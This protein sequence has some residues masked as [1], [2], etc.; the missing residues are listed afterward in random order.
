MP[1]R[2]GL[3]Y[4]QSE[5]RIRPLGESP[6][7]TAHE[8]IAADPPKLTWRDSVLPV[9]VVV[10]VAAILHYIFSR[11]I[12]GL[13][14]AMLF[15]GSR[16]GAILP[17]SSGELAIVAVIAGLSLAVKGRNR[18]VDWT[19]CLP[20]VLVA[21]WSAG[22]FLSHTTRDFKRA[23]AFQQS[24]ADYEDIQAKM[25]DPN[26]LTTLKPPISSTCQSA[27]LAAL[28]TGQRTRG[29]PLTSAEAHAILTNLGSD[30]NIEE[31]VALSRV[32]SVDDLQWLALHGRKDTRADVGQNAHTPPA[33]RR[34]LMDD[35]EVVSY[36]IGS[37]AATQ[38]CDPEVNRAFWNR[39]NRK[40]LPKTD[41]A[42]QELADNACTPKDILLE[43]KT[44][45]DPAGP[46]ARATLLKL[47][48]KT[49]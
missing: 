33:T 40:N 34:R 36:R 18:G 16:P 9:G 24:I 19:Y 42:Y 44:F 30:P 43:L 27:V 4:H 38:L 48:T 49:K 21:L 11:Y 47:S 37:A 45:P 39:E 29:I 6:V 13:L 8:P 3:S 7:S 15:F 35:L 20:A 14:M 5:I 1:S 2:T 17:P 23:K 12:F 46:K 22:L 25:R 28:S 41:L 10:V 26:F 31:A 32:T